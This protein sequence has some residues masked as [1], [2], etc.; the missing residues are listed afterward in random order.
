[1]QGL[2]VTGTEPIWEDSNGRLWG[3]VPP[4]PTLCS[5]HRSCPSHGSPS[6]HASFPRRPQDLVGQRG[7]RRKQGGVLGGASLGRS[8]GTRAP[9]SAPLFHL[10]HQPAWTRRLPLAFGET[11]PGKMGPFAIFI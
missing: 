9:L 5:G 1:M 11:T 2:S 8:Q 7:F 10:L 4:L 3:H 6:A